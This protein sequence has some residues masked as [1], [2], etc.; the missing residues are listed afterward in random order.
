VSSFSGLQPWLRPWA[1]ALLEHFRGLR[2]TSVR[3]SRTEQLKLWHNRHNNPYPVA[4]PGRS[5]HEHGLA[6]DMVGPDH[7][8]AEAGRVWNSWGGHWSP[9]DKIHFEVR[10]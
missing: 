9:K 4:P 8:L 5:L 10:T 3:R 1:Q 7:V 6:F 2:V